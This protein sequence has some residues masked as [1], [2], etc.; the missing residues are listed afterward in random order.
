MQQQFNK[1]TAAQADEIVEQD[2][3]LC[4]LSRN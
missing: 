3:T 4:E 2:C 1:E